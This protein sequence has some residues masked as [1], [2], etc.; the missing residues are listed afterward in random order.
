VNGGS[1]WGSKS[2]EK[3]EEKVGENMAQKRGKK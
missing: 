1:F 3:L 2:H